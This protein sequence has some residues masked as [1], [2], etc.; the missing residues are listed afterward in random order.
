MSRPFDEIRE[1]RVGTIVEVTGTAIRVDL[2]TSG[3]DLTRAFGGVVYPV[4][5]VASLVKIYYGRTV[6]FAYVRR[7]RMQALD[8]DKHPASEAGRR[9]AASAAAK[10]RRENRAGSAEEGVN[11]NSDRRI[12]DADLFAEADWRYAEKFLDIRRGV[13]TYPLPGQGV[14]LVTQDELR[15]VYAAL[16]RAAHPDAEGTPLLRI[17]SYVGAAGAPCYA[18]LNKLFGLHCAVLGSTGSGKSGAVA[19]ILHAALKPALGSRHP[20]IVVLDPHGEYKTAFGERSIVYSAYDSPAESAV[21]GPATTSRLLHLPYWLLT[22]DEFRDLVIGKT[23]FQATSEA[24]IV[25]KAL[26]HA[27]LVARGWIEPARDWKTAVGEIADGKDPA[28]PRPIGQHGASVAEYN[29]D[30]PDY[31]D[32]DEFA[33]HI[34]WEQGVRRDNRNKSF[35]ELS[36]SDTQSHRAIVNK[37][38]ALRRDPRLSFLMRSD[39]KRRDLARIIAQLVGRVDDAPEAD[40]RIVDLSGLPNEVAG[41]LTGAI[42]RLLFQYKLW[43][44]TSERQRDPVLLVCEEAHRY[45]PA[46]GAAE[47]QVAQTAVRRIAREGRKYGVGLMLVSQRPSDIDPTVLSQCN[48]WVVLRLTNGQDQEHIQRFLPDGLSGLVE[49]LPSLTRREAIFV[50]D[51]AV[52]PSRIEIRELSAGELPRSQ[53]VRF[54]AAWSEPQISVDTIAAVARRWRNVEIESVVDAKA[55]DVTGALHSNAPPEERV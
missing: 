47:Y 37:L 35:P 41:P 49:L 26:S 1:L 45:V 30:I 32:L 44:T 48:S 23:E 11:P 46:S 40:I 43:Q 53:D 18:D 24:N 7:L 8:D 42:A 9:T 28:D 2:N 14:Y 29:P 52:V 10:K 15:M 12:L 5:Q 50:G 3:G 27:R 21:G 54:S 31:F 55:E 19:A 38:N 6:L 4:G 34:Q 16:E 33:R 22:G 36:F 51:A 25:Y 39:S 20:R 13:R 17:G